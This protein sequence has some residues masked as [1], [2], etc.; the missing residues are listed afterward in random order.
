MT[1]AFAQ[2][3]RVL[4]DRGFSPIPIVPNS[5]RPL[6]QCAFYDHWNELRK[7]ALIPRQIDSLIRTNP[8]LGLGVAGGYNCLVPIDFDTDNPA[9]KR[10]AFHALPKV[11][12]AKQGKKGGTAFYWDSSGMIE[13]AKFK[14]RKGDGWDMLIE[15]LATGQTLLPPTHHPETLLPYKWL[16]SSTLFNTKVDELPEI[17]QQHIDDLR[18]A[19]SPW[20][21]KP[22]EMTRE[23]GISAAHNDCMKRYAKVALKQEASRLSALSQ[24]RNWGLFAAACRLGRF[25]NH[26]VL[27]EEEVKR[28]LMQASAANGYCS[29][30]HGGRSQAWKTMCSGL[31]KTKGDSLPVL[32]Q[33][34]A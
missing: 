2:Y 33:E 26:R 30:K 21:P 12:V 9:I 6:G 27:T 3:A 20:L 15:V 23:Y 24:G 13:G 31:K 14:A 29:A 22:V 16:T 34:A 25:I 1:G 8:N 11:K 32:D 18:S 19:L 10:A 7:E 5:K 4:L 28:E 17:T